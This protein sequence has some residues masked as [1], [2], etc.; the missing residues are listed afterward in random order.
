MAHKNETNWSASTSGRR[1]GRYHQKP[2][3]VFT[4]GELYERIDSLFYFHGFQ[5][6][7]NEKLKKFAQFYELL[8]REQNNV[9]LTR[10]LNLT[11]VVLKHFIDSLM[12]RNLIDIPS[13]LLD[14]GTGP[15]FPGIPLAIDN[16]ELQIFLAEGVQKRVAFLKQAREELSLPNIPIFGKNIS[17]Y[18]YYPVRSVITRA[19]EDISNTLNNVT[20][21][22][23]LG[24]LV[25]FMKGPGVDPELKS[26]K[27]NKYFKLKKDIAYEIPKTSHKRRLVVFEKI[28]HP[29]LA[30]EED[31]DF[32]LLEDA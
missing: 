2:V 8:M 31:K 26:A 18:F 10:L 12:V 6:Y 27:E 5:K 17:P 11:D 32:K 30:N 13:P 19:V 3:K 9:N 25:I 1:Q 20:S 4:G 7:P 14:V 28:K 21:C 16:P 24:G 29:P 22:L 23:E 15:G